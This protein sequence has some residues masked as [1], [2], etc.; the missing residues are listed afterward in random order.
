[1]YLHLPVVNTG[2]YADQKFAPILE[3]FCSGPKS[4]VA[5]INIVQVYCYEDSRVM[6]AFPQILKVGPRI[7][8]IV[9]KLTARLGV[10]Q[11]RLY[12]RSG[13]HLLVPEGV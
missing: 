2:I 4:Q 1:M 8:P 13:D 7:C 3:P 10:V 11:Q 9:V 12:I 6:K 5:L